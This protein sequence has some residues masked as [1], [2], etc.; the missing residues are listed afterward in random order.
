MWSAVADGVGVATEIV[1]PVLALGVTALSALL[2]VD[3]IGGLGA[4]AA[5]RERP[6]TVLNTE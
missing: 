1:A 6:A 4:N 2:V 3:V 5:I